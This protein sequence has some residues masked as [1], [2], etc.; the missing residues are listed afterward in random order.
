MADWKI[1][2]DKYLTS[3]PST[4]NFDNWCEEIVGNQFTDSFYNE[5]EDWIDSEQCTEW[6]N[7]LFVKDKTEHQASIIIERAFNI[8]LTNKTKM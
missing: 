8:F 4:D 2:L 7:K 3:G 5:N 6:L 1:S